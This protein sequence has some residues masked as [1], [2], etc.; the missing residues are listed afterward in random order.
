[1]TS[2][3][4]GVQPLHNF[5]EGKDRVANVTTPP[6]RK[7]L[8]RRHWDFASGLGRLDVLTGTVVGM[9]TLL[10]FPSPTGT[11]DVAVFPKFDWVF[12][13]ASG[14]RGGEEED[15]LGWFE[16]DEHSWFLYKGIDFPRQLSSIREGL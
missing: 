13:L 6:Q 9:D 1:L 16:T 10:K 4:F 7:N 8:L 2:Q 5:L 14:R 12:P 3:E 11:V 15:S